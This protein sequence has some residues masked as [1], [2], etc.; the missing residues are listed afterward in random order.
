MYFQAIFFL[1][2]KVH[3]TLVPVPILKDVSFTVLSLKENKVKKEMMKPVP[4][5]ASNDTGV[6]IPCKRL[7]VKEEFMCPPAELYRALTEN[8]VIA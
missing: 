4:S 2:R 7:T 5:N 1:E 6:R 8:E 3:A